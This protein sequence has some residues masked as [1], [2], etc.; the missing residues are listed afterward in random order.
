MS[1][2]TT[3]LPVEV[4]PPC[5]C[6]H[7]KSKHNCGHWNHCSEYCDCENFRE[8]LR[9]KID[10]LQARIETESRAATYWWRAYMIAT[11]GSCPEPTVE[12]NFLAVKE[13]EER[14]A[15]LAEVEG[16]LTQALTTV[17]GQ[18]LEVVRTRRAKEAAEK[19][20][21]QV[22]TWL[23]EPI[24]TSHPLVDAIFADRELGL[25]P[26]QAQRAARLVVGRIAKALGITLS[27][28]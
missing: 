8:D 24:S 20:E 15:R 19:R 2:T 17:I 7:S 27:E 11:K 1:D 26:N 25:L 4:D 16:Q 9:P 13:F 5:L 14:E 10:A 21:K 6:G 23:A 3:E 12:S 22:Q 18:Q 28:T